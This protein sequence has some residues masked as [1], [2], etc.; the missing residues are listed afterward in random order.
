MKSVIL[1]GFA[2]FIGSQI[3]RDLINKNYFVIGIDNL[4]EG[5]NSKNYSSFIK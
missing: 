3:L 5:S 1:T 2:G 4:S